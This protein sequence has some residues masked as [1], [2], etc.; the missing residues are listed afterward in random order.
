[1][2]EPPFSHGSYFIEIRNKFVEQGWINY[3][4]YG[5][6]CESLFSILARND[7]I[8]IDTNFATF[9]TRRINETFRTF[10]ENLAAR[11]PGYVLKG[12]IIINDSDRLIHMDDLLA[13]LRSKDIDRY[14]SQKELFFGNQA[15]YTTGN[16][17]E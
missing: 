9:S 16:S 4:V 14:H 7:M 1:M 8:Y 3:A 6:S 13:F 11:W 12:Q 5:S 15:R 10:S 17:Q 2:Q